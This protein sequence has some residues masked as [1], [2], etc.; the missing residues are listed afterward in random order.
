MGF[1]KRDRLKISF[2][3]FVATWIVRIWFCTIQVEIV[4]RN[5]YDTYFR[6]TKGKFNVVAATWHRNAV[7]LFYFFR[8]LGKKLVLISKSKDGEITTGV[9]RRFGYTP[10]RGSSSRG[11]RQAL[12]A[13]I[14]RMNSNEGPYLSG[15]P[16]DGPRGPARKMKKGMLILARATDAYFIPMACSGTRLITFQKSWDRTILPLPFSKMVV[17][18]DKP[19]KIPTDTSSGDLEVIRQKAEKNLDRLTEKVDLLC[20]YSGVQKETS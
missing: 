16:V 17:A 15:T 14:A 4:N 10:V 18:F 19:F 7:F 1:S 6:Q 2:L 8:T 3:S 11:G 9:A 12:N 5:I 20:K 13:L